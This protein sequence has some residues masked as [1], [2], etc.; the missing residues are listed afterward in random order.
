M[1]AKFLSSVHISY[2]DNSLIHGPLNEALDVLVFHF[3]FDI[4]SH[5]WKLILWTWNFFATQ[6]HP[7]GLI[8]NERQTNDS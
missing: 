5:F 1:I 4:H 6:E 8:S 3:Y 2:L 7:R